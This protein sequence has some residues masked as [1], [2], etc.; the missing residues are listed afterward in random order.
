MSFYFTDQIQLSFNRIFH[1]CNKDIAWEG[2][3]ELDALVKADEEG[4][5]IPGIGDVYAILARVY[6][7]P[8]FTWIEA[9][10]PEDDTKAYSYLHTAIRRG[11]AIAILQAMRTA[12]ALTPTIEKELPMTKDEAFQR[13]Y[14]GA[15]KGCSYC[16]YAIANVF[17]WEDYRILPSAQ[18]VADEGQPSAF[19]RFLKA[20][21]V[22]PDQRRLANKI[23]AIA[24][25]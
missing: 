22:Q 5:E 24:Q 12:G 4:Q 16:A 6:S 1:Q 20:L 21:F 18:K 15:Q 14:E 2:K 3:A 8:Q 17:Q 19:V 10:F 9:G 23:T 11:S 13:V 7:G 25:D